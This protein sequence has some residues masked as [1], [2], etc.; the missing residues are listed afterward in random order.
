MGSSPRADLHAGW[1]FVNVAEI[2]TLH[3]MVRSCGDGRF[4]MTSRELGQGARVWGR[5]T[6]IHALLCV[7]VWLG[8]R[9]AVNIC[10]CFPHNNVWFVY[11]NLIRCGPP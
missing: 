9:H 1:V 6:I 8:Q 3:A 5:S 11:R 7:P 2:H 10:N 4:H